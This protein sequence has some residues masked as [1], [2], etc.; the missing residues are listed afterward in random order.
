MKT[1]IATRFCCSRPLTGLTQ[2]TLM[3]DTLILQYLN[4]LVERKVGDFTSPEAFHAIKVQGFNGNRIKLLTKF[5]CQLPMKVFALVADFPIEPCEL[6]HTPP[7]TV[8]TFPFTRKFFV[9]TTKFLQGL[10]Q[11]LWVLFF[12]TRAQRQ[13]CVFHAEVCPNALTCCR[14]RFEVGVGCCYANPI[15]TASITFD[16]NTTNI[17]VPLAVFMESI[18]NFIKSPFAIIPLA[19]CKGNAIVFQRPTRFSWIGDRLELVSLFD[20]RST[21]EFLEKSVIRCVNPSQLLLNGLAWQSIPMWVCRFVS[22]PSS[23]RTLLR[24][25][26]TAGRPYTVDAATYGSI[27]APATYRQAS[28]QC[29]LCSIVPLTGIYRFS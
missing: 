20:F 23:A 5:A 12:L 8:R 7:P 27:H 21:A 15:V 29:G 17:P 13:I 28:Y 22:N 10:F 19:E 6:F 9:E 18:R 14:Q 26:H 4:E 1:A 11:R 16:G 24:S 3:F 2:L 25:S